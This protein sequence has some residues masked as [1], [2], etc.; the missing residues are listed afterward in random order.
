MGPIIYQ[1]YFIKEFLDSISLQ[2]RIENQIGNSKLKIENR[3]EN[4]TERNRRRSLPGHNPP[5][6]PT[7]LAQLA[8]PATPGSGYR[9]GI[10]PTGGT[11]QSK[12]G[13]HLLLPSLG[14]QNDDELHVDAVLSTTTEDICWS[15]RLHSDPL[16][17]LL[18]S[19][20]GDSC[21]NQ[22]TTPPQYPGHGHWRD[23]EFTLVELYKISWRITMQTLILYTI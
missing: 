23:D 1:L 8:S 18:A 4:K 2:N 16:P 12:E 20:Q 9:F 3:K 7:K 6:Q 19:S 10:R 22:V 15:P 21:P 13:C 14:R 5:H 11:H 17:R